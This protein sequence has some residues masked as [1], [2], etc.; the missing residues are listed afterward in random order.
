MIGSVLLAYAQQRFFQLIQRRNPIITAS[1]IENNYGINDV[2]DL[3]KAGFKM[4]FG[5]I[6]YDTGDVLRDLNYI[7][8]KVFAEVRKDLKLVEL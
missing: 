4:A 6:D 5:V 1:T 7:E 8:W 3:N 2:M